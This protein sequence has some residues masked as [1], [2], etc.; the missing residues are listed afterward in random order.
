MLCLNR[1]GRST[2][3][4]LI[5]LLAIAVGCQPEPIAKNDTD[6]KTKSPGSAE[7]EKTVATAPPQIDPNA[8]ADDGTVLLA[9]P[10]D[11]ELN[12]TDA[13]SVTAQPI[14]PAPS[15]DI[16]L[17]PVP[18][19]PADAKYGEPTLADAPQSSDAETFAPD[20][21]VPKA[22]T[23][24]KTENSDDAADKSEVAVE[25]DKSAQAP[26]GNLAT[27]DELN[28][29]IAED[30]PQ[31]QA[32]LLLTGQQ[33]G[34]LEPC[35]CT[36]LDRQKGGIIRRDTLLTQLKDRGW[37]VVPL[38]VGNQVRRTGRQAEIQF[39]VTANAFKTMGYKAVTL[40]FDDLHLN[41]A[42]LV[43]V[44][45]SDDVAKNPRDVYFCKHKHLRSVVLAGGTSH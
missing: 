43:Q 38:D 21:I 28:Q 11:A 18:A 30:W 41:S 26:V 39:R 23:A 40:G 7:P 12:A 1:N 2:R 37:S 25:A 16:V 34:Y 44:A 24:R 31:P 29:K 17:D 36:G 15:P 20:I 33:H 19:P 3:W 35:G 5:G 8:V 27:V 9:P 6:A 42:G 32:V 22:A 13:T 45:A 10:R 4:A 14:K